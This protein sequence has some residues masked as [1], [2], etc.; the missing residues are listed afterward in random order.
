MLTE[1]SR[2]PFTIENVYGG[3]AKVSGILSVL[4][5]ALRLEFQMSDNLIGGVLKGN[6]KEILLPLKAIES[7]EFRKNWFVANFYIRVFSLKDIQSMPNNDEGEVKLRIKRR[8]RDR[9]R[10]L[11]SHINLRLSEI[12]LEMMDDNDDY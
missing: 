10:N 4:R 5:D 6:A 12:R 11:A 8:D 9:A 7:V 3:F 1:R 2:L